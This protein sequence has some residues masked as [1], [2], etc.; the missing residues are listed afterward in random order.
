MRRR[1]RRPCE[2]GRWV[3]RCRHCSPGGLP[4]PSPPPVGQ[5]AGREEEE[6][7]R[8]EAPGGKGGLHPASDRSGEVVAG[9]GMGRRRPTCR[10]WLWR[11]KAQRPVRARAG[12]GFRSRLLH[13]SAFP[14]WGA[15]GLP[16]ASRAC[17]RSGAHRLSGSSAG[18]C[19]FLSQPRGYGW[20]ALGGAGGG[21]GAMG[22][23]AGVSALGSLALPCPVGSGGGWASG[24]GGGS[25]GPLTFGPCPWAPSLSKEPVSGPC[26]VC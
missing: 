1:G 26:C 9:Q 15:H 13:V 22:C 4:I 10:C 5:D 17:P 19:C 12:S 6:E 8:S 7:P 14:Y 2:G 25:L 3:G 16:P 11:R 18:T 23:H 24:Q 20:A 21:P